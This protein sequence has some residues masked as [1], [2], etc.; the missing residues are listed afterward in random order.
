M[1]N[2]SFFVERDPKHKVQIGIWL[3]ER[4]AFSMNKELHRVFD[5]VTLQSFL[6]KRVIIGAT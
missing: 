3:E 4:A 2:D 5:A 1:T 6:Y